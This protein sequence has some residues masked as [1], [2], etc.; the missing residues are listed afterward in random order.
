ME[1]PF[2][3]FLGRRTWS[4]AGLPAVS[5]PAGVVQGPAE[6]ADRHVALIVLYAFVTTRTTIGRRIYALGGN[7]KAAQLSGIKTQRADLLHLRQH[8][9]AGRARRADLRGAA[10]HG[11]AQGGARL[12]A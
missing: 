10:Q 8:G 11:D 7:E 6:R 4:R 2:V 1:E 5:L 9:R 12:R 3:F